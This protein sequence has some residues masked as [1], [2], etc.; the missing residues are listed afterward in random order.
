MKNFFLLI[1]SLISVTLHAQYYFNDLVSAREITRQMKSYIDNKV[2][3][4]TAKGFDQ[5]GEP[6]LVFSETHEVLDNGKMLKISSRNPI[7]SVTTY[8]FDDSGNL[9]SATDSSSDV[10]STT[11]YFH[12][13]NNRVS[14]V[15]NSLRD[16]ANDFNQEET[17]SWSY[18]T[19]GQPLKMIRTINNSDSLEIM[20]GP[21][22]NGNP[23]EERTFRRNRETGIVYYYFDEKN[24]LT[25]IVR[26]NKK[27]NRLLPDY[28]FEYDEQDRVIQKITTTTS[29]NLGYL[30]WRYVFNEKGLKTKEALFD[31][32]KQ[33]TGKIEYTYSFNQ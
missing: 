10:V 31:K 7:P 14:L 28:M 19:Q 25:D 11:I 21:D 30:I 16:M 24:R 12:D 9:V 17:H 27:A 15:K 4:V 8:R 5:R 23:G 3:K 1:S 6:I 2:S 20:F 32:E 26:F 29:Q 33:M 18:S 22:D 13:S